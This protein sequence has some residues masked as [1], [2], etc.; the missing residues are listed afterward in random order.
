M[1][2]RG[3]LAVLVA[4]LLAL[5]LVTGRA[6]VAGEGELAAAD[7]ALRRSDLPAAIDHAR[8]AARWYVP[9]APHV[10]AAYARL[11]HVARTSEALGDRDTAIA[12]WR[13]MRSAAVETAWLSQPHASEIAAADEAVARL[14]SAGSRPLLARDETPERAEKRLRALLAADEVPRAPWALL[15]VLGL[16]AMVAGGA[17][18]ASRA[19]SPDGAIDPA[20]AK[21]AALVAALGLFVYALAVWHA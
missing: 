6:L 20:R 4:V 10:A 1:S 17:A 18:A 9:G 13:A 11:L 21:V 12:A 16:L 3:A 14:A 8:R 15:L 19:V 5:A 2:V 7:G